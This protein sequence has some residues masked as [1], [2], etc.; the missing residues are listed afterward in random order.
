[1]NKLFFYFFF[2]N[3]FLLSSCSTSKKVLYLQDAVLDQP[4]QI[5]G[6]RNIIL[7]PQDQ[8]SIMVSS[9]EP[10]LAALFNLNTG[11][12]S[13]SAL[14][15]TI[16]SN[17]DIDFP[18]LGTLHVGGMTKKEV[19]DLVKQK[20]IAGDLV[21]DPVVIVEFMNL[22]ISVLGEVGSP[23]KYDITKDQIT[24]LEAISMAGDLTITGKR[25]MVLVI[26]EEDGQRITHQVDLRSRKM[27]D[28]PAYYL[29]QNDVIY[30]QPNKMRTGESTINQ[31]NLKSISLWSS[32]A[33]LLISISILVFK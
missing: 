15:Y 18:V 23:G 29:K 25:N 19:A 32:L 31:N 20:L 30:V 1:M 17:G 3:V 10:Q 4:E 2:A 6:I 16:D 9:K 33:S 13:T 8:I 24:L 11:S 21:K 12:G 26:R 22:Y 27:F 5:E 14:G 7:Q 28:S